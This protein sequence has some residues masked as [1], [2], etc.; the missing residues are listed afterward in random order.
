MVESWFKNTIIDGLTGLFALRLDSTPSSETIELTADIWI[1]VLWSKKDWGDHSMAQRCESAIERDVGRI[2]QAFM[3]LAASCDRWP[4]PKEF[5]AVLPKRP[6][7]IALPKPEFTPE[8][9][10]KNK[11]RIAEIVSGLSRPV[12][13]DHEFRPG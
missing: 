8:Q 10:K 6:D 5:L 3:E 4:S 1:K 11:R 2:N 12:S 13:E 9:I 7:P